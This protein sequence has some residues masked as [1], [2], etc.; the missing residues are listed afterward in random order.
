MV[1]SHERPRAELFDGSALEIPT[2]PTHGFPQQGRERLLR[3]DAS[4]HERAQMHQAHDAVPSCAWYCAWARVGDILDGM[5]LEI[6]SNR[7]QCT[8]VMSVLNPSLVFC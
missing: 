5:F 3:G 8:I 4:V 2:L 6:Q 7:N 1:Q